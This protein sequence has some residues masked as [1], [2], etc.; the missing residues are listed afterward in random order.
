MSTKI[1]RIAAR[2]ILDCNSRPAL[3]VDVYTY[4]GVMGRGSA[5]TG[6]SVGKYESFILRDG[7][8]NDYHGLSV[9]K[10]VDI[11]HNIIAPAVIDMDVLDQ[12]AIDEAMIALD[13]TPNKG[14]LGGNSIYSTSIACYRAAAASQRVP[15]YRYIAGGPP[16]TIPLPTFNVI[17]G[18]KNGNVKQAFNEF[19]LAPYRADSVEQAISMAVAV[20]QRLESVITRYNKGVPP[21]L[22]RSYG[23]AAPSNDPSV[24]LELMAQAVEECGFTDKMAYAL[25]CASTEMYDAKTSTY[26][27]MG[28][29]VS[30]DEIIDFAS[31]LTKR[32][33]LVFI[34]DLLDEDDWKG[35]IKANQELKRTIVIGDDFIAT[36][37]ERLNK[38]YE[39]KAVDGFILKP[40]QIGTITEAL[41]AH[42][43]AA[44]RG[45]LVIPSGRAG[46][47][48][49]DIIADLSIGLHSKIS[50]NGVPKTGERLDKMNYL[51][52]ASSENPDS[53][54]HDLSKIVRF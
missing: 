18:G 38:A 45:L 35:F 49:G 29:R 13:G 27:L 21:M 50:K 20:S 32:F 53:H 9:H 51:L 33:N 7:D 2:Q 52:R 41:N 54:L 6:T 25:D 15:L 48:I 47:V 14:K 19:M 10:A 4:D 11:V 43:F 8:E 16:K 3:E 24:V 34:E 12:K 42:H 23:W 36:N 30:S 37:P 22:G 17:N 46:G 5:P 31:E 26:E 28:N 44:E 1:E 40:N 39:L